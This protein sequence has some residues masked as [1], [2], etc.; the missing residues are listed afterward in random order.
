M[1]FGSIQEVG[2]G[3]WRIVV[4]QVP[5]VPVRRTFEIW[6]PVD[7]TELELDQVVH[8]VKEIIRRRR[9]NLEP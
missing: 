4:D 3:H 1:A 7:A 2:P 6:C 9:S 5:T 8:Q